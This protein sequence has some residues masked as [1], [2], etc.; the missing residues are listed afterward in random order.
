MLPRSIEICLSIL[1]SLDWLFSSYSFC[2][3]TRGATAV[4]IP[5]L[6]AV[7][8]SVDCLSSLVVR[9]TFMTSMAW[10]MTWATAAMEAE[11]TVTVFVL[12]MVKKVINWGVIGVGSI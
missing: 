2:L 1:L 5:V 9:S 12:M 10:V 8:S 4:S 3:L 6:R 7:C 11:S